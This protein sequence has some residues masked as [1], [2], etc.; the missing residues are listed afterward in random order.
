MD[1]YHKTKTKFIVYKKKFDFKFQRFVMWLKYY[2]YGVKLYPINQSIN[3]SIK[4]CH[5]YML[6]VT[7]NGLIV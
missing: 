6:P 7:L 2:R 5:T 4:D 1:I 3:Q